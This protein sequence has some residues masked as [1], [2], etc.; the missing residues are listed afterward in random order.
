MELLPRDLSVPVL[1]LGRAAS[2]PAVPYVVTFGTV[3]DEKEK[4]Q[5]DTKSP[6]QAAEY[7]IQEVTQ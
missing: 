2:P 7:H 5:S 3:L 6:I 1:G 4:S